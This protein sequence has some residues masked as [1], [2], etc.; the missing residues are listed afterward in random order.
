MS[1]GSLSS[2]PPGYEFVE[3]LHYGMLRYENFTIVSDPNHTQHFLYVNG[4]TCV[5]Y[6]MEMATPD[7]VYPVL[8]CILTGSLVFSLWASLSRPLFATSAET[9]RVLGFY[10]TVVFPTLF[11]L[12]FT[13]GKQLSFWTDAKGV[14]YPEE[15]ENMTYSDT[16]EFNQW[17]L[18]IPAFLLWVTTGLL[19][20]GMGP[21]QVYWLTCQDITDLFPT[22]SPVP[23]ES[24]NQQISEEC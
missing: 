3:N 18:F 8:L 24:D 14:L 21:P 9:Y 1:E 13:T 23:V 22:V 20:M 19:M 6:P 16:E 17:G 2:G 7:Q 10:V 5:S 11:A 12:T 15:F 4:S